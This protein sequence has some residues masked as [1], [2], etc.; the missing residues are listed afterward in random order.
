MVLPMRMADSDWI[1]PPA[2]CHGDLVRGECEKMPAS[3]N[4]ATYVINLARR[5]SER[6]PMN[7]Y[8]VPCSSP[9]LP[10]SR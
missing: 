10:Q 7:R 8:F 9:R 3:G 4:A 2:C 5:L 6:S 1:Y